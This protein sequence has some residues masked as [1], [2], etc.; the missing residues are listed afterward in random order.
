MA[1]CEIRVVI[2]RA[3]PVTRHELCGVKLCTLATHQEKFRTTQHLMNRTH[4]TCFETSRFNLITRVNSSL[5]PAVKL[6]K[7]HT[8]AS[9]Q[10]GSFSKFELVVDHCCCPQFGF[11]SFRVRQLHLNIL[12]LGT[13]FKLLLEVN[14]YSSKT[15]QTQRGH[16]TKGKP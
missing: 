11:I 9:Y 16:K 2:T 1:L 7:Y 8:H 4:P 14:N 15:V 12:Q 6:S 3:C 13:V 10:P 5:L